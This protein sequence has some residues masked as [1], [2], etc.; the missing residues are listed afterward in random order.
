MNDKILAIIPARCGSKGVLDKNI[1]LLA[2]KPLL[3]YS[4]ECAQE[5]NI[6][7]DII[8]STDSEKYATIAKDYGASVPFLRSSK[9][10]SDTAS[11]LSVILEVLGRL[12]HQYDIVI[13]LQ[14]TSPL[15][16]SQHIVEA[17]SLFN[18]K[19][20]DSVIS[21]TPFSHSIAWVNTLDINTLSLHNFIKSEYLNK[22]RQDLPSA[23]ILN[24]AVYIFRTNKLSNNF[25]MFGEKSYAYI[26]DKKYSYDIDDEEDFNVV[27]SLLYYKNFREN[28]MN[29][30]NI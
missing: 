20:A 2:G 6:F 10:A 26:M 29:S 8:V 5:S 13:L 7:S 24:G 27:E 15:R 28:M 12:P 21:V 23:Y 22:R 16:T 11:S 25:N 4:I 9:T 1:K 19:D 17:Y 18:S 3:A 14:P 30:L